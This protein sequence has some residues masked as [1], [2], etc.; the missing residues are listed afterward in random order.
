MNISLENNENTEQE[1]K[2]IKG[3]EDLEKMSAQIKYLNILKRENPELFDT[4]GDNR[5]AEKKW[6]EEQKSID[7]NKKENIRRWI[8]GEATFDEIFNTYHDYDP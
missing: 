8:G 5:T 2:S 1:T 6:M 4:G 7:F 3:I